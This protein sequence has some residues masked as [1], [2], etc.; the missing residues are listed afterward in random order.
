M[1]LPPA[2]DAT[3]AAGADGVLTAASAEVAPGV[4]T[5]T[6]RAELPAA[7]GLPPPPHPLSAP[8]PKNARAVRR[9]MCNPSPTGSER[10][11]FSP[12]ELASSSV[13]A[14][15]PLCF[16]GSGYVAPRKLHAHTRSRPACSL[17][18]LLRV[19]YY[20]TRLVQL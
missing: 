3:A 16:S 14:V 15:T 8:M 4:C 9:F 1:L 5:P 7:A 18:A 12:A 17:S 10:L 19:T 11:R 6:G 20:A 2:V 13:R